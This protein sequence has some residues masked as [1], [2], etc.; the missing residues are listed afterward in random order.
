[1]ENKELAILAFAVIFVIFAWLLTSFHNFVKPKIGKISLI[2]EIP[3]YPNVLTTYSM[4]D[5]QSFLMVFYQ[6][7][8]SY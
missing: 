1:M 8:L 5:L 6:F 2:S 4:S 3:I 7:V